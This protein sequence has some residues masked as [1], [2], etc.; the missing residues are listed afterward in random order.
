MESDCCCCWKVPGTAP[1][2]PA[3]HSPAGHRGVELNYSFPMFAAPQDGRGGS[4]PTGVGRGRAR[5]GWRCHLGAWT[6]ESKHRK[7]TALCR[8]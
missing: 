4:P 2:V 1:C 6:E 5:G 7:F 8:D 3:G